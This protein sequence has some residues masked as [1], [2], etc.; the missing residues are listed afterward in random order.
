MNHNSK[1]IHYTYARLYVYCLKISAMD[2][3]ALK[4]NYF[5]E[6]TTNNI[7]KLRKEEDFLE[8]TLVNIYEHTRI[9]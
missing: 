1:C 8:V 9:H 6:Y 4:W 5:S 2:K 7:K 3:F